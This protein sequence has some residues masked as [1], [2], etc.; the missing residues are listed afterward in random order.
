GA[1][2][3]IHRPPARKPSRLSRPLLVKAAA[4]AATF[5]SLSGIAAAAYGGGLPA[6]PPPLPPPTTSAPPP[7]TPPPPRTPPPPPPTTRP[8][9]LRRPRLWLVHRLGARQGARHPQ[10]TGGGVWQAGGGGRR[11]EQGDRVLR[12][13]CATRHVSI[14]DTATGSG[15]AHHR[16]AVRVPYTAW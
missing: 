1:A 4:A 6:P 5:L 13:G 3:T 12:D 9:P 14:P 2:R 16:P 7:A 15:T 11:S 8:R 10:A